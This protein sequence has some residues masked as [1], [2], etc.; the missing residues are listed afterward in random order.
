MNA[1]AVDEARADVAALAKFVD[2]SY[3]ALERSAVDA[4]N[5]EFCALLAIIDIQLRT[6]Q[7]R[8]NPMALP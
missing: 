5:A 7:G 1:Q 3:Q 6:L 8:L 2:A 4:C